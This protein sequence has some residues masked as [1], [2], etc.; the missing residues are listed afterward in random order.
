MT[1]SSANFFSELA[2]IKNVNILDPDQ[3]QYT[4]IPLK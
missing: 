4:E 1:Y 3:V 2:F